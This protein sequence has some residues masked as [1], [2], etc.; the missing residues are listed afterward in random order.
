MTKL[1]NL[2]QK[3]C[4]II[5]ANAAECVYAHCTDREKKCNCVSTLLKIAWL[6][7][8]GQAVAT[9]FVSVVWVLWHK[10][11]CS[12]MHWLGFVLAVGRKCGNRLLQHRVFE[13][14]TIV[15]WCAAM[16]SSGGEREGLSTIAWDMLS[17]QNF[18]CLSFCSPMSAALQ[19]NRQGAFVRSSHVQRRG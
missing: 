8:L 11:V 16:G 3:Q 15:C 17:P 1:W 2:L 7:Y 13:E 14:A 5:I 18:M 10:C 19:L 12:C 6:H 9:M 4:K